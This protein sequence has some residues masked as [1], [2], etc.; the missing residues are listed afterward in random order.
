MRKPHIQ[1][2]KSLFKRGLERNGKIKNILEFDEEKDG[3]IIFGRKQ[4]LFK[5]ESSF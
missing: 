4:I 1:L 5:K 2:R 3:G